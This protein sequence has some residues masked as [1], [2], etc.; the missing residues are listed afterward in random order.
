MMGYSSTPEFPAQDA[1]PAE[2]YVSG[3]HLRSQVNA[4]IRAFRVLNVS[5]QRELSRS[6]DRGDSENH[7][8]GMTSKPFAWAGMAEFGP[9]STIGSVFELVL[10][11]TNGN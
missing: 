7:L 2:T 11:Q 3:H 8:H 9:A 5:Y 10:R 1:T 4:S 6:K